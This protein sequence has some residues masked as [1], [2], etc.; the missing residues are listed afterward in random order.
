MMPGLVVKLFG[1]RWILRIV[2][3]LL[4]LVIIIPLYAFGKTWWTGQSLAKEI[5]LT[6]SDFQPSDYAREV[7]VVLGAA[8]FDGKPGPI[9]KEN[10]VA[11][12]S[13]E[14]SAS[15]HHGGGRRS[16]R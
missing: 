1:F 12:L 6:A 16:W 4:L 7:I 13:K 14:F 9:L 5:A 11:C 15:N 8:Q 2:S 3:L 10:C